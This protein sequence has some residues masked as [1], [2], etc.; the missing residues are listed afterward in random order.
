MFS[1]EKMVPDILFCTPGLHFSFSGSISE[2]IVGKFGNLEN[3]EVKVSDVRRCYQ[4]PQPP[5]MG[6]HSSFMVSLHSQYGRVS[7]QRLGLRAV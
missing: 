6:M 2:D 5:G 7:F 3:C 1:R 4:N